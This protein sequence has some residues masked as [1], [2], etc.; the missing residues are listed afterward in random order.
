MVYT[1]ENNGTTRMFIECSHKIPSNTC[2]MSYLHF[3]VSEWMR[4][5]QGC[6][7][8]GRSGARSW[9]PQSPVNLFWS[10]STKKRRHVSHYPFFSSYFLHYNVV[11][12]FKCGIYTRYDHLMHHSVHGV[13]TWSLVFHL[14]TADLRGSVDLSETQKIPYFGFGAV[15]SCRRLLVYSDTKVLGLVWIIFSSPQCGQAVTPLIPAPTPPSSNPFF[16]FRTVFP[17]V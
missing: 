1:R 14:V 7:V 12:G 5:C 3:A 9:K 6:S 13:I 11:Q 17:I 10:N 16:L 8:E 2:D 15:A 4:V